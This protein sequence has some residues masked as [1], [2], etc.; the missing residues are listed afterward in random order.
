MMIYAVLRKPYS[1][2]Y[3]PAFLNKR[4]IKNNSFITENILHVFLHCLN[5]FFVEQ[6]TVGRSQLHEVGRVGVASPPCQPFLPAHHRLKFIY[7]RLFCGREISLLQRLRTSPMMKRPGPW[8]P[9]TTGPGPFHR[10][11]L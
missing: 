10:F 11:D 6:S 4:N 2:Y 7:R 9:T 1:H 3:F 8:S 5:C